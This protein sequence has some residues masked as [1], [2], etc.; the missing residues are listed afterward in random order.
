[1]ITEPQDDPTFSIGQTAYLA[2]LIMPTLKG[3]VREMQWGGARFG[4]VYLVALEG[5]QQVWAAQRLLIDAPI[6][7]EIPIEKGCFAA[8][9][10][11]NS[12]TLIKADLPRVS[13][14]GKVLAD[15]APLLGS[16]A[17]KVDSSLPQG[18]SHWP[19]PAPEG[20]AKC[21]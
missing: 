8:E 7:S 9:A 15:H 18:R 10:R 13:S 2:S 6:P 4:W 21:R 1:M 19:F 16:S 20:V 11:Y 17:P 3:E 14:A 5:G 12:P